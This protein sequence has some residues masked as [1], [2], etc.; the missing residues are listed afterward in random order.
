MDRKDDGQLKYFLEYCS[1]LETQY[2]KVLSKEKIIQIQ[3]RYRNFSEFALLYDGRVDMELDE[4]TLIVSLT[5]WCPSLT[6]VGGISQKQQKILIDLMKSDTIVYIIPK[7][8]GICMRI[9][10][11]LFKKVKVCDRSN[12]L[13]K[14]RKKIKVVRNKERK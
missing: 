3:E 12:E 14:V 2:K 5:L 4:K 13:L 8:K 11:T 7:N 1:I 6:F 9:D 10:D